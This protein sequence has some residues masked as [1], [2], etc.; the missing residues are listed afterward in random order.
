[1][2]FIELSRDEIS[3]D[4]GI[5]AREF[6]ELMG[7]EPKNAHRDLYRA[8]DRL[9]DAVITIKEDGKISRLRWV[10]KSVE[11]HAGEGAIT[12]VWS[13]DVVKYISQL[14]ARFT[15]YKLQN[16]ALLQSSHSI[17]IYE[18]LMRF[19]TTGQRTINLDDFKLAL[20]IEDKY[21]QF[22]DLNKRVIKPSLDELNVR[23]DLSVSVDFIKNGRKIAGLAFN[24]NQSN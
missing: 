19:K 18:L 4:M 13:D 1:M 12:F 3:K 23:S 10:Q 7:I 6:A 5:S 22:Q 8:A 16:I 17:R 9:F 20:G 24:F 11:K 15:S 21:P 2:E 14:Q